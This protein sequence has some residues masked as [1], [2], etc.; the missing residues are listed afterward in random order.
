MKKHNAKYSF[1]P[2]SSSSLGPI[3]HVPPLVPVI[4]LDAPSQ[5]K[6]KAN[7]SLLVQKVLRL[8]Y[9]FS[10]GIAVIQ[11]TFLYTYTES[12]HAVCRITF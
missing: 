8:I 1:V 10:V 4:P 2:R 5:H 3:A 7:I 12:A 9:C 6:F 11:L